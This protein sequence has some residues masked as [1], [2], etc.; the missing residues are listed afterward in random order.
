MAII[1]VRVSD[2]F[3]EVL[4]EDAGKSGWSVSEQIRYELMERR[5]MLPK[6]YLPTQPTNATPVAAAPRLGRR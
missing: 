2:E 3:K 5:G 4:E 1:A 6:P